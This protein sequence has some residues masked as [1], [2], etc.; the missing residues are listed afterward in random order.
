[1]KTIFN[2][3]WILFGCFLATL[4][5]PTLASG[6]DKADSGVAD[7]PKL[8]P[9]NDWPWWRGP[10]RN[11]IAAQQAAPPTKWGEKQNVVWKVPVPGRGHSSPTVVG[12]KVFLATADEAQQVHAVVAFDRRTGKQAWITEVSQGGFPAKN[13]PKNTEA[14]STLACDGERLFATFFHHQTVQAIA[15]DLSGKKV[16]EHTVGPF[17]PKR[18]EYGYAPSPLIYR[19]TVIVSAEHDGDSYLVALDR[20]TG[21]Q[22]WRTARPANITFSSPVIAHVAGKDQLLISGGL[23]VDSFDPANGKQ[24]WTVPGT[25]MAT[26]GTLVWDGDLVFASGGYPESETMAIRAD[27]SGHVAWRNKQK[28]YEESMLAHAGYLYAFTGKG[29]LF[30]WR[31]SDGQ[32]MWKERLKGPVSSSPVLAAGHIYWTNEFGT[33]FVFQPNPKKFELIS[34]NQLG[35]EGFPSLSICGGQVFLRT[36]TGNGPKRQEFLYCLGK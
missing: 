12:D 31:A 4:A 6:A 3:G 24:L 22:V 33:T 18:Y 2:G 21:Q 36:A 5:P 14:T 13:H 25:A 35:S 10:S 16:W 11:G 17:N 29:D 7:F 8:A 26:C 15:L 9:A 20:L 32:E 1:M 34:S 28:C 19:G 27:G 30:C 23:K